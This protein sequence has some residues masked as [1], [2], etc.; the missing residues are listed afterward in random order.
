MLI[1]ILLPGSTYPILFNKQNKA[2][3]NILINL[4]KGNT[5]YHFFLNLKM[6]L[7]CTL[8]PVSENKDKTKH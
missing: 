1:V 5:S 8:F 7:L 6:L 3:Q 2:K 4:A